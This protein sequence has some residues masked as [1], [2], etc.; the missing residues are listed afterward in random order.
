MLP[1][2]SCVYHYLRILECNLRDV[3][4]QVTNWISKPESPCVF[5]QL[6]GFLV[7]PN[8]PQEPLMPPAVNRMDMVFVVL[9]QGE[10]LVLMTS[11]S[12]GLWAHKLKPRSY[13]LCWFTVNIVQ[14]INTLGYYDVSRPRFYGKYWC[15]GD[16]FGSE[17]H[18]FDVRAKWMV[19][20][21]CHSA[22]TINLIY[23]APTVMKVIT[24]WSRFSFFLLGK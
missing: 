18:C 13:W 21:W 10:A 9:A 1:W 17:L 16:S 12:P 24:R 5:D 7:V 23:K 20:S 11:H 8:L 6:S 4:P 3:T 22:I 2:A 14:F 19:L 15:M